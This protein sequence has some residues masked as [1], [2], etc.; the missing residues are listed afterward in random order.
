[1]SI[2]PL[3]RDPNLPLDPL[4]LRPWTFRPS[5]LAAWHLPHRLAA[6]H[7][8]HTLLSLLRG[9]LTLTHHLLTT[10]FLLLTHLLHHLPAVG[11]LLP[12]ALLALPATH[13][14]LTLL[15]R[16]PLLTLLLLP[17]A[18][19]L[20]RTFLT[21][22]RGSLSLLLRLRL[23]TLNLLLAATTISAA[24]PT[25]VAFTPALA[26]KVT[27]GADERDEPKRGHRR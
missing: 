18:S 4:L 27:V 5:L 6:F 25:A 7:L 11:A 2:C 20:L 16:G 10:S 23:L 8:L 9:L 19:C 1:M 21:L 26:K 24:I 17:P 15:R 22:R 13:L 14:L 12:R 3:L